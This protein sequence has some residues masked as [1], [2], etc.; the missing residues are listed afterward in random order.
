MVSPASGMK[1]STYTRALTPEAP[2]AAL[3]MTAPP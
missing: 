2:T 1:A 3:V